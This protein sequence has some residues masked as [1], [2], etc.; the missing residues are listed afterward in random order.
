MQNVS[1]E[2]ARKQ[3][4]VGTPGAVFVYRKQTESSKFILNV[5]EKLREMKHLQRIIILIQKGVD[6]L[7]IDDT[8][9]SIAL[10]LENEK[11]N[12]ERKI[13]FECFHDLT[14]ADLHKI[15]LK[16]LRQRRNS[17]CHDRTT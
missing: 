2:E 5:V 14:P 7:V 16:W 1:L 15:K 13:S 3:V 9:Q 4:P 12:E 8:L 6:P 11:L 17:E 10:L